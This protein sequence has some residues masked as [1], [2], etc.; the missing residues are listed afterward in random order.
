MLS[1]AFVPAFAGISHCE[2]SIQ[3]R[4]EIELVSDRTRVT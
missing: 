1:G 2:R 4:T 3:N